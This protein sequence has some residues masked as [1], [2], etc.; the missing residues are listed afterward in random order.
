MMNSTMKIVR[1]KVEAAYQNV[2]QDLYANGKDIY[3]AYNIKS[4]E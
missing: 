2:I 1:G 4:L 3:S